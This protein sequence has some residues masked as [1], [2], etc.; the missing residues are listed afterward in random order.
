MDGAGVDDTLL[1]ASQLGVAQHQV[2][3]AVRLL[4]GGL[5][6]PF[7]A[8]YRRAETGG[9]SE[10]QVQAIAQRLATRESGRPAKRP[11]RPASKQS[12]ARQRGTSE[13]GATYRERLEAL[14]DS[15]MA[16]SL[17][18]EPDRKATAEAQCAGDDRQPALADAVRLLGERFAEREDVRHVAEAAFRET[19]VLAVSL[20]ERPGTTTR[21][22]EPLRGYRATLNAIP[23]HRLMAINRGER[24]GVLRAE[25]DYAAQKLSRELQE[26]LF[27]PEHPHT[28]LLSGAVEFAQQRLWTAASRSLRREL[29]ERATDH[30]IEV[31]GRNLRRL[32]LGRPVRDRRVLAIA[33]S[34]RTPSAVVALDEQGQLLG[35]TS[36]SLVSED[37]A[38]ALEHLSQFVAEHRSDLIAIGNGS[39]AAAAAEMAAQFIE[40]QRDEHLAFTIV[41]EAGAKVYAESALGGEELPDCD[42][43]QRTA[44]S[45]G[46][47]ALD[48]LSELV[49]IDP[50][51]L[52]VGLYQHD[53]DPKRL[54]AALQ[55]VVRS[56][57]N[58][59]GV[60]LN[61]AS[62]AL[63]GN[64]TGL[65]PS[66]AR[67]IVE[68][69]QV[70][71][72][73]ASLEQLLQI[74]GLG[75]ARFSQAAGFLRVRGGT[76]PLDA[77]R[78]HPEQYAIAEAV[79][80]RAGC[81]RGID[82]DEA[83]RLIARWT[84]KDIQA[85][86]TR[87]V[88]ETEVVER[89]RDELARSHCDPREELAPATLL[90]SWRTT[91]A[92]A[93]GQELDALVVNVVD[94]GAFVDVGQNTT[95][96]IHV[97]QMAEEYVDDPHDVV[98]VGDVVRAWVTDIRRRR[99]VTLTMVRP[100][101]SPGVARDVGRTREHAR[102]QHRADPRAA[103]ND[104]Q[105]E[106]NAG[107][108]A[109]AQSGAMDSFAALKAWHDRVST[110]RDR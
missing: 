22:F 24:A 79:L 61:T 72:P 26:L 32:L 101:R 23:P 89:V 106:E 7:V 75:R 109:V 68:H 49:K 60:D 95:G 38:Q 4:D 50:A 21:E 59:V 18:V 82:G 15:I 63:L 1:V 90:R 11:R 71:G 85:V 34:L 16:G 13:E 28:A 10:D 48:P 94:F 70:Q 98:A 5:A 29:T 103:V 81:G 39:A 76:Q 46:R 44:V 45:I 2:Q 8:R 55:S 12:P 31:F 56:A 17:R 80:E 96:L 107:S 65:T 52:G 73:F 6:V 25:L 30:A 78:V 54:R 84:K 27:Q 43:P 14:A 37:R 58:F 99:R 77:T 9:L 69:R 57:V 87:C 104:A 40:T 97:S 86:A 88:C 20:V 83:I 19:G 91:G 93:V 100:K 92:L 64:V 66:I 41:N 62:A 33:P 51:H 53:V 108:E 110:E 102:A 3:S 105:R 42:P 74:P 35:H 36:V 47:R 67:R